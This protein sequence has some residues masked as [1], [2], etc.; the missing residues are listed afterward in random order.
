MPKLIA[1]ARRRCSSSAEPKDLLGRG[2]RGRPSPRWKA[3]RRRRVVRESGRGSAA[4]SAN[5]RRPR[6]RGPARARMPLR[7]QPAL[8]RCRTGMFCRFG[9]LD[10]SRPVAATA[11]LYDVW[12]RP[13]SR[14]HERRQ[15]V[16]DRCPSVSRAGGTRGSSPAADGSD[17]SFSRHADVGR[18]PGLRPLARVELQDLEQ[19]PLELLGESRLNCSPAS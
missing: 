14:I 1:F 18:E 2:R 10:D 4:R 12:M 17:A 7:M 9:S 3:C 5:S 6:A 16:D 13:V 15:R 19:D 8:R 11:W